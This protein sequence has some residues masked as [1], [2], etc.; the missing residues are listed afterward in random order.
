[1]VS[2]IVLIKEKMEVLSDANVFIKGTG[3]YIK[4]TINGSF[5]IYANIQDT[6]VVSYKGFEN[7]SSMH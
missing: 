6:L 3:I 2:G 4:T 5:E 1:M 7:I